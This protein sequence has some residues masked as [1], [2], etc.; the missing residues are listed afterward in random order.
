MPCDVMIMESTRGDHPIA[1]GFTRAGEEERLA[2][3]IEDVFARGGCVLIPLFALGKTQELL[4][5]LHGLRSRG[6]LGRDCPLYI[7]GLGVIMLASV[8]PPLA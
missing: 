3:A 7:G 1:A 5:V 8:A 4:A 2:K 6:R